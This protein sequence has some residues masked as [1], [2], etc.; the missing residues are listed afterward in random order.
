MIS[1][2]VSAVRETQ[3]LDRE[4]LIQWREMQTGQFAGLRE[5]V[6]SL[7]QQQ[8]RTNVLLEM[9]VKERP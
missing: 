6:Q 3:G 9:L 1:A 2:A 5:D 4:S 7:Q 8:T